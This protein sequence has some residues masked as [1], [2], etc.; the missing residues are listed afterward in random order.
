[1]EGSGKLS[2]VVTSSGE[3][4]KPLQRERAPDRGN[5]IHRGFAEANCMKFSFRGTK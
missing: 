5:N 4:G 2:W 1:M 3:D